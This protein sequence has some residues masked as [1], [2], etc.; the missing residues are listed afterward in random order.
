MKTLIFALS[1]ISLSAAAT[2]T[3][4][5]CD[6][7][8]KKA[9]LCASLT[10]VHAPVNKEMPTAKDASSFDLQFW[11]TDKGAQEKTALKDTQKFM[12]S[13]YM[14]AMKHGSLPMSIAK[15]P[16]TPGLYHVSQVLFSMGGEWEFH[17]KLKQNDK[18]V[19]QA[20]MKYELK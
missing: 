9:K 18:V 15:D 2:P 4:A 7:H 13:L 6:F 8:L 10:W 3:P 12:L 16:Q 19:D 5:G 20:S 11:K 14:P 17:M 1:L